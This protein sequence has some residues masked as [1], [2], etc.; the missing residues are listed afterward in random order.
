MKITLKLFVIPLMI[1]LSG[2]QS[3]PG[4]L[5]VK[6]NFLHLEYVEIE[7]KKY[8][9]PDTS[10]CLEREYQYS[11][12]FIGPLNKFKNVSLSNCDKITGNSPKQYVALFNWLEDVRKEI[13]SH[14]E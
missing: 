9:D 8:I 3:V 7:G 10:F 11:K 14:A 1:F 13:E 4:V 5:I 12:S 2:C 6:Q